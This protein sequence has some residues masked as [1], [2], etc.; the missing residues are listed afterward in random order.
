MTRVK[1]TAHILIRCC[2]IACCVLNGCSRSKAQ[3]PTAELAKALAEN[4]PEAM[5]AAVTAG[6]EALGKKAGEPEVADEFRPVPAEAKLM[7]RDEARRG[8][9]PHFATL[10]KMRWWKIG[11]DPTTL[12][13]PLRGPASVIT[14]NVAAVRAKLDGAERS[15]AMAKDA[16]DFLIWAQEQAG[17]GVYPFP[18]A[19]GTSKARAMEVATRFITNAEK[20][21]KLDTVVRNGWAFD[22]A[23]DGGL[24]FDNGECG[25]AM[26]DLYEVTKDRRYL[27]SARKAAD[28]AA[29][30]P[31]CPNWNYNSFSVFLLARMFAVTHEAKDLDAAIHKAR[32][33]V[34]PGQLT[35]GPHAGRWV[36]PHNARP[37]Y[38]YIMM[39]ALAQLAA[40]MPPDHA[41]R[42]EMV[43]ALSIGLKTR[44]AEMVTRG[45]MNKDHAIESLLLVNHVFKSDT[46][47]LRDTQST[48]VLDA[49][50]RLVS[51]EARRG[52]QP[53]S[54]GAWGL[55]L[56]FIASKPAAGP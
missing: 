41:A 14:G 39:R 19:R 26:L 32:L 40:V 53:L 43:G 16:A 29:A 23:G 6:R 13:A 18:A 51:E 31:L 2:I 12:T 55:F 28:W 25:A 10:E 45:V 54:P 8:F 1:P 5:H 47:F 20:A 30:R 52:K 36:D 46:A 22:D 15:L 27:D 37:A 11:V 42:P 44:N 56:E 34:I 4:N 50:G 24:Q 48:A 7:S 17:S 38:H 49:I 3:M 9:T 33:G 35:D 21:G